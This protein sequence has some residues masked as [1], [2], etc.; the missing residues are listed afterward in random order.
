MRASVTT[1]IL[2]LAAALALASL[3][4]SPA[5]GQLR[6]SSFDA[7]GLTLIVGS[8]TARL[9]YEHALAQSRSAAAIEACDIALGG[10]LSERNRIATLVN[11]SI[12]RA[13]RGELA[14]AL[15]DLDAAL[16]L[17]PEMAAIHMNFGDVYTRLARWDEADE[18]FTRAIELGFE[19]PQRAHFARAIAREESGDLAGA[20][21]DYSTASRL[22]PHWQQPKRELERFVVVSGSAG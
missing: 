16:A 4:P 9:C 3:L 12:V 6:R 17:R 7:S 18:A 11:R 8:S 20:Y 13:R 2:S 22:A 10:Y 1:S 5:H 15:E 19:P 21:D 14:D